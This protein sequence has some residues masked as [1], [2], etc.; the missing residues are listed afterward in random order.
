MT[1]EGF[2]RNS[3]YSFLYNLHEIRNESN[4]SATYEVVVRRMRYIQTQIGQ[5]LLKIAGFFS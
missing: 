1:R 4:S 5:N 3:G 2:G